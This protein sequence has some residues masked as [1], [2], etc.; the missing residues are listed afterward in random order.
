MHDSIDRLSLRTDVATATASIRMP[1]VAAILCNF[2]QKAY[3]EAAIES[4]ARQTYPYLECVVVD[5]RSTDGSGEIIERI[6]AKHNSKPF[7]F[8]QLT[9][10]IG[11]MGAM[12]RGLD[13][14]TAPFVAWLDADDIWFPEYIERHIEHHL[15]SQINAAM[16]TSNL[17]VIDAGSTIIAGAVPSMSHTNPRREWKRTTPIAASRL[18]QDCSALDHTAPTPVEPVFIN[19]HYE[20]WVWSPTSGMVFRRAVIDAVRPAD[21]RNLRICADNYLARFSHIIGGTIWIGETLGYY[22]I[23][24][25]NNFAKHTVHGDGSLG[26]EPEQIRNEGNY[27]FAKKMLD[28]S[29]LMLTLIPKYNRSGLISQI[30]RKA[31]A[32]EQILA[33]RKLFEELP[34][35]LRT[36]IMRRY[37][38][39]RLRGLFGRP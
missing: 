29:D 7:Q 3:I 24:G 38:G 13:A 9:E 2:N 35:K 16:S 1:T 22:R 10:N 20:A 4:V 14:T 26:M 36:R 17:A 30:G 8:I 31:R 37:A 12:M 21:T 27:Q 6:L 28:S 19:R 32:I 11:Q 15:N 23:H 34:F 5:D 25:G 33:N 18:T 39:D